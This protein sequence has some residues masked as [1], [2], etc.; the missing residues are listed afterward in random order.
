[1]RPRHAR[2]SR[3]LPGQAATKLRHRVASSRGPSQPATASSHP[4]GRWC[5]PSTRS[6][7][8]QTDPLLLH[9]VVVGVSQTDVLDT[10]WRTGGGH[11]G[12][13]VRNGALLHE[14]D[15]PVADWTA[16][17]EELLAAGLTR[18]ARTKVAAV[19][20]DLAGGT[21]PS[22]VARKVGVGYAT[23]ARIAETAKR[24]QR[25]STGADP[26]PGSYDGCTK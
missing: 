1:M 20:A 19:F 7:V 11:N 2:G 15:A 13:S 24:L 21:A 4:S 14:L 6:V 17:A 25:A 5:Q 9:F 3:A 26:E 22:T 8:P 10:P 23:V 12:A 16:A 18:T